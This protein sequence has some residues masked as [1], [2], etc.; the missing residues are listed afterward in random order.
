MKHD[1]ELIRAAAALG[2]ALTLRQIEQALKFDEDNERR[3]QA[4]ADLARIHERKD[5]A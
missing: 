5:A 3:A 4:K 2:D 1:P